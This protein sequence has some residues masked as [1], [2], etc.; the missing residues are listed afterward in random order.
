MSEEKCTVVH[1][2]HHAQQKLCQNRP[3]YRQG[4]KLTAVKV[5]TINDES[6]H[7]LIHGVPQLQ[8]A[9]E[10]KKLI[11]SYGNVKAIKLV[12]EYP[13]EEFTE[14]YHVHYTHIQSARIAKRLIDNKNFFGGFLHVCYAPEL[15]TLDETKSKLIQRRKDVAT[16]IKRIQQELMNPGVDKFIPREQYHRK[17]KTPTLPLTEERIKHFY[18][19]ETL[20]SICNEILPNRDL[21]PVSEARLSIN[22]KSDY[23]NSTV[24]SAESYPV[25]YQSTEAL[26]QTGSQQ[27]DKNLDSSVRKQKNYRVRCINKVKVVRPRLIDTR[28]ITRS[29]FSEKTNVFCNVKKVES[30]IT[31]KLLEKPNN[32]KKIVI[33]NP[34]VISLIQS[35]K[36][37]QSSIQAVKTQIRTIMQK[38]DT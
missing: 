29:N 18:P 23:N 26:M 16:Q 9:Q 30:K 21:R 13:L 31:I 5:Y 11:Y 24:S 1:M 14:T 33:K 35:S 25:P 3:L 27:A 7:L 32:E 10:V 20:S 22:W 28:N 15:E 34:S 19:G 38:H 12:T 37:L 17:K 6:Q 2:P 8:L 36:D 4:K